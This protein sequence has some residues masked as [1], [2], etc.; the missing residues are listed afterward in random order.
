MIKVTKVTLRA[1]SHATMKATL[2]Y[3]HCK[4][5][6]LVQV[7]M[8]ARETKSSFGET[9]ISLAVGRCNVKPSFELH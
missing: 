4:T 3:I 9:P 1:V 2:P 7:E 6:Q 5:K 8:A